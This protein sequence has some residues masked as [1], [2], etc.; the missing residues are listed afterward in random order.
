MGWEGMAEGRS[1]QSLSN[2][3]IFSRVLS[4]SCNS[5]TVALLSSVGYVEKQSIF[6]K[7]HRK[8]PQ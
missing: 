1:T 3:P 7:V 2:F 4:I 5:F 6:E 8:V